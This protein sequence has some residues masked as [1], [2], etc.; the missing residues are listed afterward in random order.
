MDNFLIDEE[1]YFNAQTF[2]EED[3]ANSLNINYLVKEINTAPTKLKNQLKLNH[4]EFGE[5]HDDDEEEEKVAIDPKRKSSVVAWEEGSSP[6][7]KLSSMS[8]KLQKQKLQR[9]SGRK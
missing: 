6:I 4:K 3:D 5:S 1:T 9:K 7:K 8:I 2:N